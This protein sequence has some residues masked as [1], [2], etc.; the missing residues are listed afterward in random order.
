MSIGFGSGERRIRGIGEQVQKPQIRYKIPQAK[1]LLISLKKQVI[2]KR[3][4]YKIS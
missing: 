3:L 2:S 4:R 1:N